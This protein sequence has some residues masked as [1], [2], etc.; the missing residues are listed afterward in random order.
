ME[1]QKLAE[2]QRQEIVLVAIYL[3]SQYGKKE[4]VSHS[5]LVDC[6]TEIQKEI[7]L[8]YE[9]AKK[10]PYYSYELS[11]DLNDLWL[12]KRYIR[13]YKYRSPLLPKN[14]VGLWPLGRGHAKK[15]VETLDPEMFE[16]LNKAV[17]TIIKKGG[18]N[19]K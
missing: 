14:F 19:G 15:V 4:E 3:L 18:K 11:E 16:V 13:R 2:E 8:G 1:K 17:R 7:T 6:L 12:H 10:L 9:F 5:A